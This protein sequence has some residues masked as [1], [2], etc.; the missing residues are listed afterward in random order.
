MPLV[1][2]FSLAAVAMAAG[3][4]N[5]VAGGG[6]LLTF[7]SLLFFGCPPTVANATSTLALMLGTSGSLWGYR[8]HMPSIAPWLARFAP[9][10]LAGGAVGCLLLT[11]GGDKIFV[12][13]VPFLVLFAS[14]LFVAQGAVRQ[15]IRTEISPGFVESPPLGILALALAFQFLVSVYGGYFGAGI[16]ILMLA[17]LG[18]LGFR[19][20]HEMNAAKMVLSA[21]INLVASGWFLFSGLVDVP[22]AAVM[23]GGAVIG[24]FVGAHFSQKIPQAQVRRLIMV[25]GFSLS[26]VLF[27]RQFL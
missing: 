24:Y 20:I 27:Y 14:V 17:A 13:V 15:L 10:S 21:L 23:T 11:R 6:T 8:S 3:A 25:I 26:A 5:A 2:F 1:E 19:N 12:A 22:K 4:I 7:P 18:F 16:G 9:V